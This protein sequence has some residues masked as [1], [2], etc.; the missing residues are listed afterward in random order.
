M[1]RWLRSAISATAFPGQLG[2]DFAGRKELLRIAVMWKAA[3]PGV[4]DLLEL[5]GAA[6]VQLAEEMR[7]A[8]KA[9]E[10]LYLTVAIRKVFNTGTAAESHVSSLRAR[11][12]ALEFQENEAKTSSKPVKG[13]T[14]VESQEQGL[15]EKGCDEARTSLVQRFYAYL[16]SKME[17]RGTYLETLSNGT[18]DGSRLL[19]RTVIEEFGSGC[20]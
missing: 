15:T 8:A 4:Q 7:S 13:S 9:S 18:A 16:K 11:G 10:D 5:K 19:E 3:V 14:K 6:G 1:L 20:L 12:I 2:V 17:K